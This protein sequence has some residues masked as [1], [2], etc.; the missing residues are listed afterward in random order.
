MMYDGIEWQYLGN[1]DL[2][3][4]HPISMAIDP[5]GNPWVAYQDFGANKRL[6]VK[7]ISTWYPQLRTLKMRSLPF[8][9]FPTPP[10]VSS[11]CVIPQEALPDF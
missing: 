7:N 4:L 3:M 10:M 9:C 5:E 2:P 8:G 6:S 11:P 1:P